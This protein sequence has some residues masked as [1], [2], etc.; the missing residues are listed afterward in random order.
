MH[1][2]RQQHPPADL[3]RGVHAGVA[4]CAEEHDTESARDAQRRD[5]A[6]ER[7]HGAT[8]GQRGLG[9]G[10]DWLTREESRIDHELAG[11]AVERRQ[12][13]DRH[14]AEQEAQGR[15]RHQAGQA[16]ELFHVDGVRGLVHRAG[17]IKQLA[18]EEGVVQHVQQPAGKAECHERGVAPG[19][20]QAADAEADAGDADVLG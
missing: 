17:G 11:E 15:P 4:G 8:C 3:M 12:R 16:A 1:P 5:G 9:P 10:A 14:A 13:R 19:Q 18:L 20:T 7:E 6:D 2:H